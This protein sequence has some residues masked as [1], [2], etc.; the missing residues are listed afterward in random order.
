MQDR[1]LD[2]SASSNRTRLS[3]KGFE[4]ATGYQVRIVSTDE[5]SERT[6]CRDGQD[7]EASQDIGQ[8]FD[9]GWTTGEW[10]DSGDRPQH[11]LMAN[12]CFAGVVARKAGETVEV[13]L[14]HSQPMMGEEL[15]KSFDADD[16]LG[17]IMGTSE[18][19]FRRKAAGLLTTR[20]GLVSIKPGDDPHILKQRRDRA[21]FNR[22]KFENSH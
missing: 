3:L 5:W 13:K 2:T 12:P 9:L 15:V 16:V 17:G 20:L 7:E 10:L 1:K 21:S 14:F 8:Q 4:Q 19:S 22:V 11:V 18:L 6:R